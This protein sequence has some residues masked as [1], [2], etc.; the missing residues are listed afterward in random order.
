MAINIGGS[1]IN[2]IYVG[3]TKVKSIY[4]GDNLVYSNEPAIIDDSYNYFVFDTSLFPEGSN[5]TIVFQ[6]YDM[7]DETDN[8]TDWGDGIIDSSQKHTYTK[9]GIYTVKT[10]R[11]INRMS[12]GSGDSNT[13]KALIECLNI[14]KNLTNYSYLFSNCKSLRSIGKCDTTNV[15]DMSYTFSFT[16]FESLDLSDWVAP[17]VS[18][19]NNMFYN[20]KLLVTLNLSSFITQTTNTNGMFKYCNALTYLDI[21]NFFMDY[22]TSNYS[23][24]FTSCNKLSI[25]NVIMTNCSS[26]TQSKIQTLINSK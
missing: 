12:G 14:S 4:L 7:V 8:L 20:C 16:S 11:L 5:K 25:D 24:M 1:S 9:D 26:Y 3:D 22:T 17:K 23:G 10:K 13:R 18:S 19:T 2:S 15:T 21:S 6:A